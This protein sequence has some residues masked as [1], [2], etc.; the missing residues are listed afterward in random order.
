MEPQGLANKA[1]MQHIPRLPTGAALLQGCCVPARGPG[2]QQ[3]GWPM[4][5]GCSP[6][7]ASGADCIATS[8]WTEASGRTPALLST[9]TGS[10]T[11]ARTVS[12][13]WRPSTLLPGFLLLQCDTCSKHCNAV[14]VGWALLGSIQSPRWGAILCYLAICAGKLYHQLL[15]SR[16]SALARESCPEV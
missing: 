1:A 2:G 5:R 8:L 14:F 6:W 9:T 4:M 16:T 11:R 3:P 15:V 7:P 13:G 10:W 12:E